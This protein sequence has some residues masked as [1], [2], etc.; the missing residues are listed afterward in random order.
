METSDA[1]KAGKSNSVALNEFKRETLFHRQAQAALTGG[2]SKL[3]SLGV[4][5][6]RP[7]D[8]FAEM[9]KTDDHM[10]KV[11]QSNTFK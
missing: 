6:T 2:I 4:S 1:V 11:N 9:M 3:R 8:N 5:T 10:Q 7:E